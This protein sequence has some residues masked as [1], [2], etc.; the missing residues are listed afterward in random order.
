MGCSLLL[1]LMPDVHNLKKF[2][3]GPAGRK[4]K[5]LDAKLEEA[6]SL[7]SCRYSPTTPKQSQASYLV[8]F[9]SMYI[10]V[11]CVN[12][13]TWCQ[14]RPWPLSLLGLAKKHGLIRVAYRRQYVLSCW[15]SLVRSTAGQHP[16]QAMLANSRHQHEVCMYCM[17]SHIGRPRPTQQNI[18]DG[19]TGQVKSGC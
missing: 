2:A 6:Q 7:H 14:S 4:M 11:Q 8:S 10:K 12:A 13:G 17:S 1:G 3:D 9:D 16:R 18:L 15:L 5:V 19:I